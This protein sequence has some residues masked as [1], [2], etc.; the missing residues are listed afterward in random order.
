MPSAVTPPPRNSSVAGSPPRNRRRLVLGL[1]VFAACIVAAALVWSR[2][3]PFERATVIENLQEASDSQVQARA[4]HRT[5]FPSPG[6]VLDGVVF[7]HGTGTHPLIS[8]DRVTV[9]GSYS[10]ILTRHI[11][12]ITAEGM[13]VFIP[14]FDTGQPF[15]T[16]RSTLTIGEIVTQGAT[17]EF[18]S[19]NP[20]G[21]PLRFDIHQAL[22]SNVGWNSPL[23]Y[24][25]S[26]HNPDPPGEISAEG[27][28]GVW[29][30]SDPAKT[31]VSG[32]YKF[33]HADLGV[34]HGIAGMLSSIGEFGGNLGHIDISG[35]TDT[36]NFE[37]T[38]GKH[39]VQLM[40][41]FSAYVDATHGDT[42]LKRV[43]AHF[44]K[45]HVVA[46]GSVAKSAKN[47]GKT[48]LIDLSTSKGRIEDILG[49]FVKRD[50]APMS[51]AVTLRARV[52][53]PPGDQPFL[54]RVILKGNFGIGGGE[55]SAPATQEGVDKL[56]AG[57]RGEKDSSDPETV[58]TDLT[59]QVLLENGV[60]HFSDLSF[61]VPGAAAR[62]HGVYNV[63]NHKIDLR[64]QMQVDSKIS[65]TTSG[66]KAFL[67][68]MMDPFFKKRKK[69]EILPVRISGT[70]ESP[71][72]GLDLGD[73]KAQVAPP[74]QSKP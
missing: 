44:R 39:P 14:A 66:A 64:G 13:R 6:C 19:R 73:K 10:G 53:I 20:G 26:L 7:L 37:V 22:F 36:P 27:K 74:S 41:E 42:F 68:K 31:P 30:Q 4:F 25:V 5:Y 9:Q 60:A 28:F 45:T 54:E 32:K 33:E 51:G 43:D 69:G 8:I 62:M 15:H 46:Q 61:G 34:Y 3:W 52:E 70:Y 11:S 29:D 35:T 40:T 59:G 50:R 49:L 58:V 18:A 24:R 2:W 12:R 67:L 38:M 63:I 16:T 72:F 55:F 47:D 56:S 23:S 65:N 17:L 1:I 71:S 21:H 48:A 57:S